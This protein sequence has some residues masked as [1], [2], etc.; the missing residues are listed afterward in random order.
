MSKLIKV[1]LVKCI[2]KT[3]LLSLIFLPCLAQETINIVGD[4]WDGY[5][6]ADGTGV[7]FELISEVYSDYAINFQID[8]YNRS[9]NAFKQANV[10]IFVG[11][12]REDLPKA[13]LPNWHL[14]IDYPISVF[15]LKESPKISASSDLENIQLSWLR[16]YSFEKYL[17]KIEPPYLVNDIFKGFELLQ[18]KRI[19]GFID[20]SYNVPGNLQGKLNQHQVMPSRHMYLAFQNNVHGRKLAQIFDEKMLQLRNSG[21]LKELYKEDYDHSQFE[22]FTPE[23]EKIII[24]TDE[25]NL[26]KAY[27]AEVTEHASTLNHIYSLV[28]DQL[29]NYSI[30]FR[31]VK[32]F[33]QISYLDSD[34]NICFSDK[35]K[36]DKRL[37]KFIFSQP[38]SLYLGLRLYSHHELTSLSS[39]DL[40]DYINNNEVKLGR[41]SGRSYGVEIDKALTKVDRSKQTPITTDTSLA[42]K[43]LL[44]ERFDLIIEYPQEAHFYWPQH[45]NNSLYSY[46]IEGA[47]KYNLGHLMCHKSVLGQTFIDDFNAGL[48]KVTSTSAFYHAL[49]NKLDKGSK[50]LFDK[51]FSAEFKK[52]P[53]A[54]Q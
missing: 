2:L 12:Y 6:H 35:L 25:P 11:V 26:V 28:F 34:K 51:Y 30:E 42:M 53:Y 7:Y 3:C 14:D 15:T 24:Y 5:S 41:V 9:L 50:A 31:I 43:L 52:V 20:Y 13:I 27:K 38:L 16:G 17:P 40:F 18:N 49:S 33:T 46:T 22:L 39:I 10:D 4:E 48:K 19:D 45:S 37:E 54:N 44:K 21:K 29:N 32:D 8:S 36:T 23:K 47:P 1:F